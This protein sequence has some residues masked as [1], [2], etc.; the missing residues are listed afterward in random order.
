[1]TPRWA[2]AVVSPVKISETTS[3]VVSGDGSSGWKVETPEIVGSRSPGVTMDG[4][5]ILGLS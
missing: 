3:A 4:D 2:P 1:M 5:V